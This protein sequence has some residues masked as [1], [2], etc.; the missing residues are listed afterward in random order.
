VSETKRQMCLSKKYVKSLEQAQLERD[1]D[2]DDELVIPHL[3]FE[4]ETTF[5]VPISTRNELGKIEKTGK[6]RI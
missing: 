4:D 1:E 5:W 3:K 6:I 2:D